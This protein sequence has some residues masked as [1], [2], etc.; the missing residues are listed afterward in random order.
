MDG[1]SHLLVADP[2]KEAVFRI[3]LADETEWKRTGQVDFVDNSLSARSGTIRTRAIVEN[4]DRLLTPGVFG[5]IQL[6][7]GEYDALLIPDSSVVSDQARKIVFVVGSDN[8]VQGRPVTLGPLIDGLRVVRGGLKPDDKVVLDGL[9]N[10]MVRP[11]AKIAPQ[12]GQITAK[13]Q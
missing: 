2:G 3:K 12:K 1:Q 11:G 9:A 13:A 8:V 5:R 6:Y 7:G 4:K 10:P